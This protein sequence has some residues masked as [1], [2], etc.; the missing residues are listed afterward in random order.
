MLL[1]Q[2]VQRG[3]G[4][5][6]AR[7]TPRGRLAHHRRQSLL[8]LPTGASSLTA[9]CRMLPYQT[10]VA[11]THAD[12]ERHSHFF[13]RSST[14]EG[15]VTGSSSSSVIRTSCGFSDFMQSARHNVHAGISQEKPAGE[16]HRSRSYKD[17]LFGQCRACCAAAAAR[18][19]K[20]LVTR[21][22]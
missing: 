8:A 14:Q 2:A 11:A 5:G 3:G 15:L 1:L 19:A 9:H 7:Q 4:G 17:G 20:P 18:R 6:A 22:E 12:I 13:M 16:F 21:L 10:A